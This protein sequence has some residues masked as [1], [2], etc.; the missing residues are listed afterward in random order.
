VTS[1]LDWKGRGIQLQQATNFPDSDRTLL[2]VL[3]TPTDAWTLHL[4]VPSWTTSDCAVLINGKKVQAVSSPGSYLAIR[5]V[6]KAGDRVEFFVPMS[7][8]AE[9][10]RD[11][12]AKQAFL[13]GPIVLAGQFPRGEIPFEFE[14]TQAPEVG[15]LLPFKVPDLK[16]R[17]E[18][19][20]DWIQPLPGKPLHFIATGQS[21]VVTL[22]PLNQSWGRFAVY[23]TVI[24]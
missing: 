22:K 16:A 24:E 17:G 10:L 23:W 20:E 21:Q 13:Y 18:K 1:R 2:S 7:L 8:T 11:D 15:E 6:W 19:P 4:R 5:R 14:H 9:P 12:P 3:S